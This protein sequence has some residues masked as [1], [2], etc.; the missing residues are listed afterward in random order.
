MKVKILRNTVANRK[1]VEIGQIVELSKQESEYL[2]ARKMAEIAVEPVIVAQAAPIIET[3][4][5]KPAIETADKPRAKR[6]E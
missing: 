6:K 3:A 1:P 4:D 5:L 2:I